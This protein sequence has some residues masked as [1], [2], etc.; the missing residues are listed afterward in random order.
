MTLA[1]ATTKSPRR[2]L[3]NVSNGAGDVYSNDYVQ[4][5]RQSTVPQTIEPRLTTADHASRL[6]L[7]RIDATNAA[8]YPPADLNK[9]RAASARAPVDSSP[10][11]WFWQM[12]GDEWPRDGHSYAVAKKRHRRMV[13]RSELPAHLTR[14]AHLHLSTHASQLDEYRTAER[15]RE[16]TRDRS[17]RVRPEDDGAQAA[18]RKKAK[19]KEQ[20]EAEDQA[21]RASRVSLDV[22]RDGYV[23][24]LVWRSADRYWLQEKRQRCPVSRMRPVQRTVWDSDGIASHSVSVWHDGSVEVRRQR[25]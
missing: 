12:T 14:R 18:L 5:E 15:E 20:R 13:R 16:R 17:E 6:G 1:M 25:Y 8:L 3:G 4:T 19:R 7:P 23:R 22:Q 9:F 21:C 11:L 24:L 2:P 10:A